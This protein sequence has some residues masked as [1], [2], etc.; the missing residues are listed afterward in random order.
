MNVDLITRMMK[1]QRMLL[2]DVSAMY[3]C[4]V[5]SVTL[6]NRLVTLNSVQDRN[7]YV[8]F[9]WFRQEYININAMHTLKRPCIEFGVV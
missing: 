8:Y 9:H 7:M 6:Q 5:L 2:S 1:Y 3:T 4:L